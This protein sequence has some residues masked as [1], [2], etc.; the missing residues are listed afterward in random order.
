M[1]RVALYGFA[2]MSLVITYSANT[3]LLIYDSCCSD[4][5]RV[6][7]FGQCAMPCTTQEEEARQDSLASSNI[8]STTSVVDSRSTLATT[9][10]RRRSARDKKIT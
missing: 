3:L 5:T 6:N 1:L 4:Y 7:E 9:E 8:S 10:T 2:A